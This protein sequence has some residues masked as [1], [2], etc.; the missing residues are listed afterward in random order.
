MKFSGFVI[1]VSVAAS[2]I[3][4]AARPLTEGDWPVILEVSS[5]VLLAAIGFRVDVLLGGALALSA[6]GDFFLGVRRWG[7]LEG[8]SLFLIGLGS[9]LIAHLVYVAMFRRYRMD[10]RKLGPA[11]VLGVIAIVLA[12]GA[13]LGMLRASL[14]NLLI[15][16]VV[17]AVVLCVMGISAMLA[18][19][20]TPLA[21]I[22]ALLFIASDAMLAVSKFR[23]PYLGSVQLIWT[24]YYVAQA[25]IL[26]GVA[27]R[28]QTA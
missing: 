13:V 22:G 17:Y 10:L 9:F 21:A 11:R 20:G 27:H 12:L 18:D 15:P 6:V 19:L 3:F 24:S 7:R 23:G 28:R 14:G 5:I 26:R 25:F 1:G 8:E 4:L 2:F 16:V